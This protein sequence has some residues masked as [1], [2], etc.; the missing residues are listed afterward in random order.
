METRKPTAGWEYTGLRV[1]AKVTYLNPN[2]VCPFNV[3]F[4]GRVS[5]MCSDVSL[6]AHGNYIWFLRFK[7]SHGN[8]QHCK[9]GLD[10]V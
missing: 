7:P 5:R 1:W 9:C 8:R 3:Y 6:D 10:L 2:P 4:I